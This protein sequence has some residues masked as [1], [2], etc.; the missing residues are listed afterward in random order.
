MS[1]NTLL[2]ELEANFASS[3]PKIPIGSHHGRRIFKNMK[4]CEVM[5]IIILA[6]GLGALGRSP[7][8]CYPPVAGLSNGYLPTTTSHSL[9][10][11]RKATLT[12]SS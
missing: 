12:C 8:G 5:K 11:A 4:L 2:T 1:E 3:F 10:W 7:P 9:G 6:T